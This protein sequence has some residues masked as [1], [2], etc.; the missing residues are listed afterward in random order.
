MRPIGQLPHMGSTWLSRRERLAAAVVS[1][2]SRAA[3]QRSA[4]SRKRSWE[5]AGSTYSPRVLSPS[6]WAKNARASRLVLNVLV[7]S[8]PSGVR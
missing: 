4:S 7:R 6:T 8:L 2:T 5:P 3:H 1:S